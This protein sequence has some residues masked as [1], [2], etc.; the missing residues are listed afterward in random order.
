MALYLLSL[1]LPAVWKEDD[2]WLHGTLTQST[3]PGWGAFIAG[4]LSLVYGYIAWLANPLFIAAYRTRIADNRFIYA[5]LAL[6][7]GLSV[8][9]QLVTWYDEDGRFTVIGYSYGYYVWLLS[10]VWLAGLA[11]LS[12]WEKTKSM[13]TSEERPLH[14]RRWIVVWLMAAVVYWYHVP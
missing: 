4:L 14:I 10:F 12:G 11:V 7:A 8:Q 6:M 5:V 2:N 1:M 9:L 13:T 3:L